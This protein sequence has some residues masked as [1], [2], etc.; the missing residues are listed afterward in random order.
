VGVNGGSSITFNEGP[1][2][3]IFS[4]KDLRERSNPLIPQE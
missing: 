1:F 3:F 4:R 2:D